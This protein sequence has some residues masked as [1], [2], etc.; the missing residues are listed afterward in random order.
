MDADFR[1]NTNEEYRIITCSC[2]AA[3]NNVV[4]HENE[5]ALAEKTPV[6][7]DA[8]GESARAWLRVG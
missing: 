1:V 6:L 3:L 5:P 2:H 7:E 8:R 4:E